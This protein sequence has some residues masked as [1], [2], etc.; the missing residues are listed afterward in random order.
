GLDQA[1]EASLVNGITTISIR[2]RYFTILP[3]AIGTF[4]E[5]DTSNGAVLFDID[6]LNRFMR[7]VQFLIL[8]ATIRDSH[9]SSTRGALGSDLWDDEMAALKAGRN[10][11]FP[12]KG[13]EAFLG[14][15]FGPARALGLIADAPPGSPAPYKMT[16]RGTEIFELRGQLLNGSPIVEVLK[17]GEVLDP[18]IVDLAVPEF[19]LGAMSAFGDE[20]A[21]LC[22]ALFEPWKSEVLRTTERV[23]VAYRQFAGSIAWLNAALDENPGS[24]TSVLNRNLSKRC[25]IGDTNEIADRWAEYEWRRRCHY[26]LEL[27]LS[28]VTKTLI[29][30]GD[31]NLPSLISRWREQSSDQ[32]AIVSAWSVPADLWQRSA[33]DACN[34]IPEQLFL[35]ESLPT[36]KINALSAGEQALMAFGLIAALEKQTRR[37]R[38]RVSTRRG[39]GECAI[40][41]VVAADHTPFQEFLEL[42]VAETVVSPH[43]LT[44]LQKMANDLKCSLRFFSDGPVLRATG[45]MSQP[46]FSNDRLG[47]VMRILADI[48]ELAEK[49]GGYAP[50][51]GSRS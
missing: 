10:V 33:K 6:R 7:R 49:A 45:I 42:L 9:A 48:G 14:T 3:W 15:Y 39:P 4:T 13:S 22:R 24:A 47:N 29:E 19:S 25:G 1:I 27:M 38:E 51:D 41:M 11:P 2:A 23:A 35:G 43:L 37:L 12:T 32:T 26:A 5:I 20:A 40:A 30:F 46:G 21:M 36:Q 28:A 44:T 18:Q 8:A 17:H 50:K 16:S 34:S 31:N